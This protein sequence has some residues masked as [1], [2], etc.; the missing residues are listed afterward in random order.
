MEPG[1][2]KVVVYKSEYYSSSAPIELEE[3]EMK[4]MDWTLQEEIPQNFLMKLISWITGLIG[5]I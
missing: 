4:E 1:K 2:Y 5:M 3:G